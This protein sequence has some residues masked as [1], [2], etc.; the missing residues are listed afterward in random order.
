MANPFATIK[1]FPN[2]ATGH[3]IQWWID[4]Y[5]KGQE[6][7]HFTLEV[8]Q[9]LNFDEL[10]FQ[11]DAG[12]NYFV[13]DDSKIKQ[14]WGNDYLY[15]I[16][17]ETAD[18]QV[19]YSPITVFSRTRFD[20]KKL[21]YMSE[22]IRKEFLNIRY[23]G[24]MGYLL[25]RKSYGTVAEADVDPVSGVPMNDNP[26]SFGTGF[27]GGYFSPVEVGWVVLQSDYELNLGDD[28]PLK[29]EVTQVVRIPGYPFIGRR[30]IIVDPAEDKRWNVHKVSPTYFPGTDVPVVQKCELRLIPSSDT[31]YNIKL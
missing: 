25:K 7:Y 20:K 18:G 24:R 15:R 16:R 29:E 14:N 22:I 19:L 21:A 30:D 6:P 10:I 3:Y 9:T 4:P 12:S 28:G 31:I 1:V 11:K 13:I 5:F 23:G 27:E 26:T 2:F 8:S 17:M